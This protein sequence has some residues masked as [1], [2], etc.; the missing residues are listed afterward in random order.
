MVTSSTEY[1]I[2][3]KGMSPPVRKRDKPL[4]TYG[5]RQAQPP[6]P[7]SD[8]PP[9]KKR[10]HSEVE[11][12]NDPA[13]KE[14]VEVK[15]AAQNKDA[16]RSP[17]QP[18]SGKATASKGSILSYFTRVQV[19]PIKSATKEE[20]EDEQE[21]EQETSVPRAK[22]RKTRLLRLR[23]TS[24]DTSEE[25]PPASED[26][27]EASK[28]P[29]AESEAKREPLEECATA[30][31]QQERRVAQKKTAAPSVQMTLN[32]SP[33]AAFSECKVCDTVWNPLY[34]DDVKYHQKRHA[35][36][37]RKSRRAMEEL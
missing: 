1:A 20:P 19:Q 31:N 14:N 34:P 24:T 13:G 6:A 4:R 21:K 12:G 5:K 7:T 32:I 26:T 23:T 36:V 3:K 17:D 2:T 8:E 18:A 29:G 11:E 16:I 30:S 15:P 27:N 28:K 9:T 33:Q 25:A 37:V 22:R 35:A 10:R